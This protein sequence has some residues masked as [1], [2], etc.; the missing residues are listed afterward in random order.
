MPNFAFRYQAVRSSENVDA[1]AVGVS[2]DSEPAKA[3]ILMKSR[4]LW[5]I[6]WFD[7][8]LLGLGTVFP[9]TVAFVVFRADGIVQRI[10]PQLV[11]LR[12]LRLRL[13]STKTE[14]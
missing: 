11:G 13:T 1:N 9:G 8:Q 7:G 2:S 5:N 10:F 3:A 4:L 14:P 12:A 6:A